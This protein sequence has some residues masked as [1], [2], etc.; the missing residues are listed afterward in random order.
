[1]RVTWVEKNRVFSS[2][3]AVLEAAHSQLD[4]P[5]AAKSDLVR[6]NIFSRRPCLQFRRLG[7]ML[8]NEV[9]R[10]TKR[11]VICPHCVA[12]DLLLCAAGFLEGTASSKEK[13]EEK[14]KGELV[15]RGKKSSEC[16]IK[17]SPLRAD[18]SQEAYGVKQMIA[19]CGSR[20]VN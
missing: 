5:P 20:D 7:H 19:E 4:R 9:G 10:Q 8:R 12:I 1:M 15:G 3:C 16:S 14:R 6:G 11:V 2:V 13:K 18:T 17:R